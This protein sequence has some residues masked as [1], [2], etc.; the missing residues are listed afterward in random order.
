MKQPIHKLYKYPRSLHLPNSQGIT[1][2]DKVLSQDIVDSWNWEV[3]ISEKRD[4][5]NFSLYSDYFHARSLNFEPHPSRNRIAALHSRIAYQI[6]TNFRICGENLTAVHSIKYCNLKEIFEVFGIWNEEQCLS[7]DDT[8][9][10]A[11]LLNLPTVP[12]L[13]Q[14]IWGESV[15]K[16]IVETLDTSKQEGFVV[17]PTRAFY[18]NEFNSVVG[19]WVRHNHVISTSHWIRQKIEYNELS[20]VL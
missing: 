18:L 2:D 15:A 3:V 17:R 14:G 16:S 8:V 12:I 19:K 6:P 10:F 4:G 13:Y 1:S 7:W 5:E 11:N 9:I 20:S